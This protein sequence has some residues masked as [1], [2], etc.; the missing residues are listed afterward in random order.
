MPDET[1]PPRLTHLNDAGQTHMVDV[2]GKPATRRE[3]VASGCVLMAPATLAA[4]MAGGLPKG[5]AL[6]VAR[7][8]GIMAAKETPR[9]VPLCHQIPLGSVSVEFTADDAASAIVITATAATV[10]QTGAEMEA[11]TAVSVA[12]L[13]IYDMAKAIDKA[14]VIS[15]IRLER[16]SGGKS[17]DFAR[18]AGG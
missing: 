17:G 3:A 14:M 16:K 7:V 4:L 18:V 8:A 6:A 10:G 5:D 12:A 11:L 2:S 9:L 1:T 15:D 13:T